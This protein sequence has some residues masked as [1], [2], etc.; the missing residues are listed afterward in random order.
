MI[1]LVMDADGVFVDF[2]GGVLR[3]TKILTGRDV[4]RSQLTNWDIFK[5]LEE[6]TGHKGLADLLGEHVDAPGFCAALEPCEGAEAALQDLLHL[7]RAAEIH[8]QILTTPWQ[9]SPT[10]AH[11]RAR[12]FARRGL[13]VSRVTHSAVKDKWH[14]DIFVDDKPEHVRE[15][16]AR[17]HNQEGHAFLWPCSHNVHEKTLPRL[18]GW[19]H[20]IDTIRMVAA[21]KKLARR[22]A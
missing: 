14:A 1:E 15:W 18:D 3:E 20:L 17:H 12:W 7:D 6:I 19:D 4:A 8:L 21:K 16:A 9:G 11:E 13:H 2:I 22:G 10:W 5:D